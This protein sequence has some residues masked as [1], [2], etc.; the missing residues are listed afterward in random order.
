M[1][2]P[3]YCALE[4]NC[5]YILVA[6]PWRDVADLVVCFSDRNLFFC[7]FFS[8]CFR[9]CSI[10]RAGLVRDGIECDFNANWINSLLKFY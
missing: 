1:E 3:R 8:A 9:L 10:Q 2:W 6:V 5:I 7:V 4:S